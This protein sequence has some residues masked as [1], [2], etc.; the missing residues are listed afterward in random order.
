[1][2]RELFYDVWFL[3]PEI[4]QYKASF[5]Y[6]DNMT[7][8]NKLNMFKMPAEAA[9]IGQECLSDG[10]RIVGRIS[11]GADRDRI[12]KS[13]THLLLISL[14]LRRVGLFS[15]NLKLPITPAQILCV[16]HYI[17]IKFITLSVEGNGKKKVVCQSITFK[18]N[19]K[20]FRIWLHVC[21]VLYFL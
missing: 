9:G 7:E 2:T 8:Y 20:R 16:P 15:T 17:S 3:D 13:F 11:S 4:I 12:R 5:G 1:M 6:L 19:P 21:I 14:W 18:R 10:V